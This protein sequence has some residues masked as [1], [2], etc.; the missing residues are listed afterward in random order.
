VRVE[1]RNETDDDAG[2]GQQVEHCVK[3]LVPDPTAAA[4]GSVEQH[5][6]KE[7]KHDFLFY[8]FR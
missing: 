7:R 3:Q 5:R 4:T 8:I 2:D 1:D 6:W